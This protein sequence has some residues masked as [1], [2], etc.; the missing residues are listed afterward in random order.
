MSR[1]GGG[2][3][4]RHGRR[5]PGTLRTAGSD[6][7]PVK[8]TVVCVLDR[9]GRV[10]TAR[11]FFEP[12]R[13][14]VVDRAQ[15]A[16]PGDL[17]LLRAPRPGKAGHPK[18]LR[19]IGRPD[20]ASDVLEALMLDRGLERRFP[21]GVTKAAEAARDNLVDPAGDRRRDLRE[22][23]TFTID[24]ATA[25]DFDDAISAEALDGERR[26]VY[27]HIADVSAYVR[28]GSAVDRE[29]R[30]RSTSVY[31]PGRV[32]PMLPDALSNDACSLREGVDRLAVTVEI[33]L[34]DARV[35]KVSAYRSTI[36]SDVRMNYGLVD[37]IF[38]GAQEVDDRIAG[39]L[40]VARA[41]AAALEARRTQHG[42]LTVESSEPVF[43]FTR[44]GHVE[45]A[46]VEVQTESHRLVE[47]LMVLA[48]E[49]V[50][51]LLTNARIPALHRVHEKPD[52]EK[53]RRLLHQLA[54]LGVPTPPAADVA[55][56]TA[57][58]AVVAEASKMVAAHAAATGHGGRAFGSLVLRSLK[59]ARYAPGGSG[60]AGLHLEHYCHFTSPIR[61][62][63]DLVCH[64]ALLSLV[65]MG[66]E[67][68][69]SAGMEEAGVWCSARERAA[70][71]IERDADDIARAFLLERVLFE[72]GHDQQWEGE[73]VGLIGAGAFVAFGDGFEGMLPVRRLRDEGWWELNEEGTILSADGSEA[74]LCLG[75]PIRVRVVGIETA[76]GRV[77][78]DRGAPD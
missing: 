63:P 39:T 78:L 45:A 6:E 61:R 8:T 46:Q 23:P 13:F 4:P 1:R 47:H 21:P 31:V 68:P 38:A 59:Q 11:P 9:R 65:G 35:T 2:P 32:E 27:V 57:A 26:R 30:R 60:H 29:A 15:N 43:A 72:Q 40:A 50:A 42:A 66:E 75:D 54:S 62:Y 28:P 3:P 34:D 20:N 18:V 19:R 7:P 70:M 44:S 41:A 51:T 12:G 58:A 5:A 76:R 49:Q 77:D 48:N 33:E 69:R 16:G 73:V 53:V 37:D 74:T 71:T 36:R 25:Q 56:A 55:T 67:E 10:V 52:P 24:P 14:H 17:V 64:R 22:L